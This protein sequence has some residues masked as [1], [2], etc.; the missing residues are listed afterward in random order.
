MS[1]PAPLAVIVG[2]TWRACL[3]AKRRL[4]L[5]LP[6]LGAVMFGLIANAVASAS[7]DSPQDVFAA[8]TSSALFGIVLPVACLVIGDAVLGAEVRSGTIHFTWLSP[9][10]RLTI[11]VGRWLAGTVVAGVALAAACGLSAVLAGVPEVAI[12]VAV[13]AATG[14]A[15]Y[16]SVFVMVG[17]VARRAVVWSL[18]VVVLVERLLGAA[19]DG[20]AQWSPGWLARAAFG[21]LTGAEDL[22]RDGVP[23]GN[24]AVARLALLTVICLAVAAWRLGS[25]QVAGRGD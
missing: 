13:A 17:A 18:V 15:A 4:G 22:V 2:Y 5:L 24:A 9:V 14:T 8:V 3:P 25:L 7:G 19:L 6:S 23:A 20:V 16:V 1:A 12:E 10:S 21:G 11:V